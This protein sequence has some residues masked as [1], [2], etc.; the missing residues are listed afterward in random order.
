M[1]S[2]MFDLNIEKILD[3]WE[4]YHAIREIIANAIDEQSISNTRSISIYQDNNNLWHIRDYGRGIKYEH[5]TQNENQEKLH[6]PNLIGKF[7]IG[8]KDALATFE[9]NSIK[10]LIKSKYGDISIHKSKKH[11][12]NDIITLHAIIDEPSIPEIVGTD[13]ILEGVSEQDINRA[14][15]LFLL[16]AE[17]ETIDTTKAGQILRRSN[18]SASIYLNGMKVAD[19]DNFLFS[20][21]ITSL[22][23][24]IRG[25]LNR[26]RTNVG[27]VAYSDRVKLILKSSESEIIAQMLTDD[28]EALTKGEMHDEL[29]WIDVQEHAVKILNSSKKVIFVSSNDI[30][31]NPDTIDS[32]MRDGIKIIAIPDNLAN[33]IRGQEDIAGNPIIELTHFI[34]TYNE[35]FK[36][37]IVDYS[38]LSLSERK[39]FDLKKSIL[40]LIGGLP[41]QVKAIHVS[42]SMREE[43]GQTTTVGCWDESTQSIIIKRSQLASIERFAGTLLHEIAHASSH[44]GDVTRMFEAELT[45]TIG[46]I[47]AKHIHANKGNKRNQYK[48]TDKQIALIPN[49]KWMDLVDQYIDEDQPQIALKIALEV[50]TD[51]IIDAQR[52]VGNMYARGVGTP[53]NDEEAIVW[54]TRAAEQGDYKSQ[55]NLGVMYF[56]GFGVIQD[57]YQARLW[58]EKAAWQAWQGSVDDQ[59]NLEIMHETDDGVAQN[60]DN[61]KETIAKTERS[62]QKRLQPWDLL[63][64]DQKMSDLLVLRLKLLHEKRREEAENMHLLY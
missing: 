27:R 13:F 52:T 47:V 26:E 39:I 19:E 28:L 5:L 50:A 59:I 24:K 10:V 57:H 25:A 64:V 18:G 4:T 55:H 33:K 34:K 41:K 40:D 21:N 3:N 15:E 11:G 36:F 35:S 23:S 56:Q 46:K 44:Y 38:S 9:R 12:F 42:E 43:Y 53:Q 37:E 45:N 60:Y 62:E 16:F 1:D 49:A 14:K 32:A 61:S 17:E 7:G 51:G 31:S 8:L 2:K 48:E 20:Y 22:D 6:N 30:I 58:F 54:Y 29:K 63:K